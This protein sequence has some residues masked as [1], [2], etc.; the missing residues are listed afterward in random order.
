MITSP[1]ISISETIVGI[2]SG[3]NANDYFGDAN[4]GNYM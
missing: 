3:N 2:V 4:Y 1:R